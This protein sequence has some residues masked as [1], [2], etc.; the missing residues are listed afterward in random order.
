MDETR[1]LYMTFRNQAGNSCTISVDDPKLDIQEQ[2]IINAMN[3]IVTLN[4]FQPKG[5]D[6]VECVGAKIVNAETTEFDLEL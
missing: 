6:L 2:E 4:I 1:V 5:F 3:T